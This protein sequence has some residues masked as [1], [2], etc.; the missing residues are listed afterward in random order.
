MPFCLAHP[1]SCGL[2]WGESRRRLGWT[3]RH[4]G[5]DG[6]D[7]KMGEC[8]LLADSRDPSRSRVTRQETTGDLPFPLFRTFSSLSIILCCSLTLPPPTLSP[9]S[10]VYLVSP[11]FCTFSFVLSVTLSLVLYF[12][13]CMSY[14]VPYSQSNISEVIII[15]CLIILMMLE[16]GDNCS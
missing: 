7:K 15:T 11:P 5:D 1:Q 12:L 16:I 9:L 3:P 6:K 4:E 13:F 10:V 2:L 14:S 8:F